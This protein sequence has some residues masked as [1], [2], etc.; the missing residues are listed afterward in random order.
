MED[1]C[2]HDTVK[3]DQLESKAN[4]DDKSSSDNNVQRSP[5]SRNIKR[6]LSLPSILYYS[7]K[8]T[9]DILKCQNEIKNER[10]KERKRVSV[11]CQNAAFLLFF[12]FL[13]QVHIFTALINNY[14]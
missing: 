11:K 12:L 10:E 3:S 9:F 1:L 6:S 4:C 8:L 5:K 14:V 13:R 2:Y 7:Q